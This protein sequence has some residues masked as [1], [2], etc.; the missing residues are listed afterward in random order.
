MKINQYLYYG[1][2]GVIS[3]LSLFFLPFL[4]SSVGLAF[5]IPTTFAGWIVF[6]ATKLIIAI[7][8]VLIFHCFQRQAVVNISQHQSYLRAKSILQQQKRKEVMPRS[9][10]KFLFHTY[11]EKGTSI[12]ITSILSVFALTQAI[13]TFDWI[14]FLTYL[15]TI[16]MGVI[17]GIISMKSS[18]EYWTNEYLNYAEVQLQESLD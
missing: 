12:F 18:E 7:I 4:G 15:F 13:L 6:I 3:F 9:P 10:H 8:N 11:A 16:I 17:F 5:V 14:S 1:I 2:I